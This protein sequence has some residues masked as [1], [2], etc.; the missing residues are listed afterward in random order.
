MS[1]KCTVGQLKLKVQRTP[2]ALRRLGPQIGPQ[3]ASQVGIRL[4][5]TALQAWV[6]SFEHIFEMRQIQ[7]T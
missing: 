7:T 2:Q 3:L 6:F 1:W 5:T 4:Q